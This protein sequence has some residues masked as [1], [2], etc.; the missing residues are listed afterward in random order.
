MGVSSTLLTGPVSTQEVVTN[1][2]VYS[3]DRIFTGSLPGQR[4]QINIESNWTTG[5]PMIRG[6]S[7]SLERVDGGTDPPAVPET[8]PTYAPNR[9]RKPGV[10]LAPAPAPAP[11]SPSPWPNRPTPPAPGQ[12]P[13]PYIPPGPSPMP[14]PT[15]P[16]EYVNNPDR[17]GLP[18]SPFPIPGAT[19]TG[20]NLAPAP[21]SLGTG[22]GTG[23]QSSPSR[24]GPLQNGSGVTVFRPVSVP[25]NS[26]PG[27]RTPVTN[28]TPPLLRPTPDVVKVP[29]PVPQARPEPPNKLCLYERQRVAD[30]QTKATETRE[31][32]A[33]PVSG[34]PGLYG[35]QIES[36]AKLGQTFSLLQTVDN[37]M[38]T[39]WRATRMDKVLN[40][41]TFIGVMHN[42]AM[43][44]RDVGETFFQL[45]SQALQAVG[46]RDEEDNVIDVGE[47]V[48]NTVENFLKAILSEPVYNGIGEAWNKANRIISSAS[49]IIW[50]VRSIADSSL[51]LMEW[52]SENTGKIGNALKRWGVVGERAY[53]DMSESARAQNRFRSRFSRVTN[54]LERAEDYVSTGLQATSTVIEI[55]EETQ[56]LGE[57]WQRF[58]ESVEEG[59]PDPWADNAPIAAQYAADKAVSDGPDVPPSE[60]QKGS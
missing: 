10:N 55:Q 36:R 9:A 11:S 37:F 26:R 21:N 60:A 4:V 17:P 47:V 49:A 57:N 48:G 54:T 32:A 39:A 12:Q 18:T 40:L 50:T 15:P 2:P 42:V 33:N 35:L 52:I 19:G 23:T 1:S 45:I 56:E 5:D 31:R 41:L 28:L 34:F 24:G 58:R 59:I 46:V 6:N 8:P 22:L 38:R 53:P 51:D 13:L 44:S 29:V 3:K 27:P 20:V 25:G 43:L 7:A 30:I 14:R 16:D